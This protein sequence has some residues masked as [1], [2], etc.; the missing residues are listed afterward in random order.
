MKKKIAFLIILFNAFILNAQIMRIT[1]TDGAKYD[2]NAKYI[3]L[4]EMIPA[5][6]DDP[7]QPTNLYDY[8]EEL[9]ATVGGI[10]FNYK[11]E[12]NVTVECFTGWKCANCPTIIEFIT[13]ELA[14]C[15]NINYS[16]MHMTSNSFSQGHPDGFNS[17]WAD[18][19]AALCIGEPELQ[20][21]PT[22]MVNRIYDGTSPKDIKERT[23][24]EN[25][26][27]ATG[28]KQAI[29]LSA[30]LQT[31][32]NNEYKLSVLV[33]YNDALHFGSVD[34]NEYYIQAFII[35]DLV[36]R[37]QQS[38]SGFIRDY[39]AYNILRQNVFET[40]SGTPANIISGQDKKYA[41]VEQSFILDDVIVP[42]NSRVLVIVYK[43]STNEVY[44]SCIVNLGGSMSMNGDEDSQNSDK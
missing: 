25:N 11:R 35:E 16:F 9:Q 1:T 28:Q 20:P 40:L 3:S 24:S 8:E 36:A 10:E 44:N 13:T 17:H 27:I 7:E 5:E 32:V 19:L 2:F 41:L 42:E 14:E 31:G 30:K 37:L 4:V 34:N 38:S 22:V 33:D 6:T 15:A 39:Q 29:W 18:S 43:K 23:L 26:R 12:N 21:L